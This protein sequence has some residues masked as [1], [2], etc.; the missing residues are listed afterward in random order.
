MYK[1]EF[2][3]SF[4]KDLKRLPKPLIEKIQ[5]VINDIKE[6]PEIGD[7][8]LGDLNG[9]YSYHLKYRGVEYRLGYTTYDNFVYF[10]MFKVRENFYELFKR[11]I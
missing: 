8:L 5:V 3:S 2:H 4:P 11:R 9:Y 7:K 6:D 1:A 10:L